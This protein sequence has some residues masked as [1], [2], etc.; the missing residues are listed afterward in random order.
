MTTSK[1]RLQHKQHHGN[2]V[3]CVDVVECPASGRLLVDK[4]TDMT[5]CRALSSA[6]L[7]ELDIL[8]ALQPAKSSSSS[9]SLLLTKSAMTPSQ[10]PHGAHHIVR[11]IKHQLIGHRLHVWQEYCA[12]GDLLSGLS[13]EA[14]MHKAGLLR[15][16]DSLVGT[17]GATAKL[18]SQLVAGVAYMH[19][20][21]IA[22]L[23][24]SLENVF[25]TD[26]NSVRIGD[27]EH[28]Q[29]W[30]RDDD[31]LPVK[32]PVTSV[33]KPAYA[34]PELHWSKAAMLPIDASKADAWSLGIMLWMMWTNKPLVRHA[35]R[36]DAMF[37]QMTERGS[38]PALLQTKL[39]AN[40]SPALCDLLRRLLDPNP[41]SRL[42]VRDAMQHPWL[43]PPAQ[44]S[45][46][47]ARRGRHRS[48]SVGST[49]QGREISLDH[50]RVPLRSSAL[51]V[52]TATVAM[53][54]L[55][56]PLGLA[57]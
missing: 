18:F 12:N 30:S 17:E 55:S 47:L 19:A 27:F 15:A 16:E 38:L 41:K 7:H 57:L 28:A 56:S 46:G 26:D 25:L 5:A 54:P 34:A 50:H 3:Q 45:A 9:S 39:L 35:T 32:T 6:A 43:A 10:L 4:Q 31:G 29:R 51:G 1:R 40:A 42:A 36:E 52:R 23:D 13:Q 11:Y 2:T 49:H 21:G 22:H 53:P 8:L 14:R 37:R 33:G 48:I 24:L 20:R 44:L